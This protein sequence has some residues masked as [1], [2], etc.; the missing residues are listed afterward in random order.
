[1]FAFN[2]NFGKQDHVVTGVRGNFNKQEQYVRRNKKYVV[3]G[4][5]FN[6]LFGDVIQDVR[7][8]VIKDVRGDIIQDVRGA[9]IKD[10]R[11]AVIQDVH[12][13]VI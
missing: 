5:V 1:M 11:G 10:V 3:G 13:N 12:G 2:I 8:D 6:N 4:D 9:V 7:G